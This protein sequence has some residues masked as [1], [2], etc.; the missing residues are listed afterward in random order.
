MNGTVPSFKELTTE[1]RKWIHKQITVS[2][3]IYSQDVTSVQNVW[4]RNWIGCLMN[5]P[6]TGPSLSDYIKPRNMSSLAS[7]LHGGCSDPTEGWKSGRRWSDASPCKVKDH[8]CQVQMRLLSSGNT[9]LQS[10]CLEEVDQGLWFLRVQD[11]E[12][13][14]NG[15]VWV[16]DGYR[17][18][19]L[20]TG[21]SGNSLR[22]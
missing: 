15:P 12:I 10:R 19:L 22:P 16:G 1:W 5:D 17:K 20:D 11:I 7:V 6:A 3:W 21:S 8:K 4:P 2:A 18:V 9:D 14:S 13:T